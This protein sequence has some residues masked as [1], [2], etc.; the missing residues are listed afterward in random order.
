MSKSYYVEQRQPPS[1]V[2]KRSESNINRNIRQGGE[3]EGFGPESENNSHPQGF[4]TK[5]QIKR[6]DA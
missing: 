4:Q 6:N 1:T 5:T 3:K 2:K